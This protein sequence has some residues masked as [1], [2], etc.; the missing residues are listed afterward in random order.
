MYLHLCSSLGGCPSTPRSPRFSGRSAANT[1]ACAVQLEGEIPVISKQ[2]RVVKA[3]V[4][5]MTAIRDLAVQRNP[6]GDGGDGG[7]MFRRVVYDCAFPS[8]QV[9]CAFLQAVNN[10]RGVVWN[11]LRPPVVSLRF[12]FDLR[13]NDVCPSTLSYSLTLQ[14]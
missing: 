12:S 1:E 5:P 13:R 6:P 9:L 10:I 4:K 2:V 3:T 7:M 8:L 14:R 11:S